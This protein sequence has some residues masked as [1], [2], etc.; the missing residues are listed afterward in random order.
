MSESMYSSSDDLN[1][2][3]NITHVFEND[4]NS[5]QVIRVMKPE[6]E[7]GISSLPDLYVER[8]FSRQHSFNVMLLGPTGVG[9]STLI[10]S[11]FKTKF[12]DESTRSHS[13]SKVDIISNFYDLEENRIKLRLGVIEVKGFGDQIARGL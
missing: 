4:H 9:K 1:F 13:L 2:M 8:L 11:I 6:S 12:T 5:G 10:D 7:V 3:P